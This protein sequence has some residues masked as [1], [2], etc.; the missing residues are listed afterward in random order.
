MCTFFFAN[1]CMKPP[2]NLSP[3]PPSP[4]RE[5]GRACGLLCLFRISNIV[6]FDFRISAVTFCRRRDVARNVS[7]IGDKNVA[8][9]DTALT[10]CAPPPLLWRG[11]RG[12]GLIHN[13]FL[14]IPRS[15]L[16]YP[17]DV[18]SGFD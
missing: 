10:F 3:L 1:V 13:H 9:P 4:Q 8:T 17:R 14:R 5:G 7:T 11:G 18:N 15:I 16:F 6:L 2:P 12:R